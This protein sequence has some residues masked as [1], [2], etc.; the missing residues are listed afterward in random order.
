MFNLTNKFCE[1]IEDIFTDIDFIKTGS[2][3]KDYLGNV[4]C[5]F[6]IEVSSFYKNDKKQCCM[7]AFV[8]GIN[9][10]CIRGRTWEE[11]ETI[12]NKCVEHYQLNIN[13]RL[14]IYVH[15]LSYEFQFIKH[16]FIWSEIF[17][18]EPRKP[19]YAISSNGI[20]F[21]CSYLL[22]GLSLAK[23]GENLLKYKVAK[24]VGDLDYQLIRHSKTPLN[25]KEWGYILNDGLV[26][27][28]FIQEEIER[29]GDITCLPKTKTGYV[30]NLCK[31]N[32]LNSV[33]GYDYRRII[34]R[35]TMTTEDYQQL[36]R[37]YSGGFTHANHSKVGIE[38]V[39]VSSYDFT[40]SYPSAFLSEKYPM[41]KA[42]YINHLTK[43]EFMTYL[44]HYACMFDIVFYNIEAKVDYEHYISRNRCQRIKD[45]VLDNGRLVSASELRITLTEQ[46]YFII[47]QMYSWEKISVGNFAYFYKDYLPKEIIMTILELYKDKTTLKGVSGKESEYMNSKGMLNSM[48]GMCVTDPCKDLAL[49]EEGKG[50]YVQH[51]D[52]NEMIEKYNKSFSRVLFY[53]WGVW[54]TAYARRNLFSGINE[55][56]EDYIYSDTDSIK[57]LNRE[58]HLDYINKYNDNV[59]QK[60]NKCLKHY[61]INISMACPKTIKGVEKPLGVWDYEGTY[62]RFKTLGAKR[63]IYETNDNEIHITISGVSKVSGVKYLK[64]KYKTNDRIFKHFED[65]LV[66]PSTYVIDNEICN[67]S[68]KLC[69][70]YLEDFM[71]DTITDYLGTE[72]NYTEYSGVHLEP[73]SYEM[74]LDEIFKNYILGELTYLTK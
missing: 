49:Y 73:T 30:R 16:R 6:D 37:A 55:F 64:S 14:I 70:T 38:N 72:G 26:V 57:V 43:E 54:N 65:N 50:W 11:F 18:I 59:K 62:L 71:C 20:E 4:A 51:N 7:Y 21:R 32:C 66:F 40:S 15:N 35:L 27:M 67:G 48:Y 3:H 53:A 41:S 1:N 10:K 42:H 24:M 34:K 44:N 17:S 69:H 74:S 23:V 61:N 9:G 47:A 19:L 46:D 25:D 29:L 39:N 56:K 8:F 2:K 5:V 33:N 28:A 60:I 36:R 68:G 45:Y 13:R 22:S 63:Y 31:E 12:I 52:L 58:S